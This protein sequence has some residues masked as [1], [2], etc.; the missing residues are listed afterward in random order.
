MR[1]L[2]VR[3]LSYGHSRARVRSCFSLKRLELAS[4]ASQRSV[5]IYLHSSPPIKLLTIVTFVRDRMHIYSLGTGVCVLME[6][7]FFAEYLMKLILKCF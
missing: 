2:R 1:N 7:I 6:K 4:S 5:L 3:T